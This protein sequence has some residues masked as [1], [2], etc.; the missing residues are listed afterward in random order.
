MS[1]PRTGGWSHRLA[2]SPASLATIRMIAISA[3]NTRDSPTVAPSSTYRRKSR[4]A[5]SDEIANALP[6]GCRIL[7][8]GQPR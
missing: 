2:S 6:C 7:A 4:R 5:R 8:N 1:W 3:S